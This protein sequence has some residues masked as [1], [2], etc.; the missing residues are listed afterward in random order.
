MPASAPNGA[1][2]KSFGEPPSAARAGNDGDQRPPSAGKAKISKSMKK[3]KFRGKGEGF[4]IA[5]ESD[6]RMLSA[7]TIISSRPELLGIFDYFPLYENSWS[8]KNSQAGELFDLRIILRA[9][10][11]ENINLA[12]EPLVSEESYSSA[13]N[14]YSSAYATTLSEFAMLKI[15]YLMRNIAERSTSYSHFQKLYS[16]PAEIETSKVGNTAKDFFKTQFKFKVN[17]PENYWEYGQVPLYQLLYDLC[18]LSALAS[19]ELLNFHPRK[20]SLIDDKVAINTNFGA[21]MKLV[22]ATAPD[23]GLK[24]GMNLGG[25]N[26]TSS[27]DSQDSGGIGSAGSVPQ[28]VETLCTIIARDLSASIAL[29]RVRDEDSAADQELVKIVEK[30]LPEGFLSKG[31]KQSKMN[32]FKAIA[33]FDRWPRT[34]SDISKFKKERQGK[35][36]YIDQVPRD[37][38][39]TLS[40]RSSNVLYADNISKSY[41]KKAGGEKTFK[42]MKNVVDSAFNLKTG[43]LD[44]TEYKQITE[45]IT[46]DSRALGI[47]YKSLFRLL[48]RKN[49]EEEETYTGLTV[50]EGESPTSPASIFAISLDVLN[51]RYAEKLKSALHKQNKK[52]AQ[53][54]DY[55]RC[56][57]WVF[58]QQF[59]VEAKSILKAFFKDYQTG[60]LTAKAVPSEDEETGKLLDPEYFEPL[61][62]NSASLA[63][64][65]T[66]LGGIIGQIREGPVRKMKT[67]VQQQDLTSLPID[68]D[69][70]PNVVDFTSAVCYDPYISISDKGDYRMNSTWYRNEKVTTSKYKTSTEEFE[71]SGIKENKRYYYVKIVVGEIIDSFLE[72]IRK[73]VNTVEEV[74]PVDGDPYFPAIINIKSPYGTASI[75]FADTYFAEFDTEYWVPTAEKFLTLFTR[76]SDQSLLYSGRSLDD[77]LDH[78]VD[79]MHDILDNNFDFLEL[80]KRE[81][82]RSTT[83]T[84]PPEVDGDESSIYREK[85]YITLNTVLISLKS[86]SE[87]FDSA[88]SNLPANDRTAGS[89][90]GNPPPPPGSG[91]PDPPMWPPDPPGPPPYP[92]APS[93]PDPGGAFDLSYMKMDAIQ[94]YVDKADNLIRKFLS[95]E[96][97]RAGNFSYIRDDVTEAANTQLSKFAAY[98]SETMATLLEEDQTA[99]VGFDIIEK[100]GD[101]VEGYSQ[102]AI[103]ALDAKDGEGDL[104]DYIMTLSKAGNT[105]ADILENINPQQLSL[106]MVTFQRQIGNENE[107]FV[108]YYSLMNNNVIKGIKQLNLNRSLLGTEGLNVRTILV[109]LPA[110]LI[111]SYNLQ[112]GLSL[113]VNNVDLEYNDLVFKPKYYNYDPSVYLLSTDIEKTNFEGVN[114]FKEFVKKVSFTKIK[115]AIDDGTTADPT[116]SI[117]ETDTNI[118]AND[119]DI[120]IFANHTISFL[121]ECYYR[122][123][124]G[125]E[126]NEDTFLSD[127]GALGLGVSTSSINLAGVLSSVYSTVDQSGNAVGINANEL[128]DDYAMAVEDRIITPGDFSEVSEELMSQCRNALTS[129]LLSPEQ[130]RDNILA[131]KMF[132]R[133]F[134]L[135]IDPDEFEIATRENCKNEN[136]NV[137]YTSFKVVNRYLKKRIIRKAGTDEDGNPIYKL[138]SRRKSEGRMAFNQ[139]FVSVGTLVTDPDDQVKL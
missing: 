39:L 70:P 20:L 23:F 37:Y 95:Y 82:A 14:G 8:G 98:C 17:N 66:A 86:T 91:M 90:P 116:M 46:A 117:D 79:C 87:F 52:E 51:R 36:V 41:P 25:S 49:L 136:D 112:N 81:M 60:W 137:S 123:M 50:V 80:K 42:S 33:G 122:I 10:D 69:E 138:A 38:G 133:V 96:K 47:A 21:A 2:K 44:F 58:I 129:R 76:S 97:S 7:K 114:T 134:M 125:L 18:F 3:N 89:N 124:T 40:L 118:S 115:F 64:R 104:K 131:A 53:Q 72:V 109:G 105:G 120:N 48:D 135:M 107:S 34:R 73:V 77:F 57:G 59:P 100:F 32:I 1:G 45:N 16:M 9:A 121:L 92:P 62:G 84:H 127:Y 30:Y 54:I 5:T 24:G 126:V 13:L 101:R 132:D 83:T 71:E 102:T 43:Q 119:S 27:S 85:E 31:T 75:N 11:M 56:Q 15:V 26:T 67:Y 94:H 113:V 28:T 19:P 106:K 55:N 74:E 99:G 6:T 63:S 4:S 110:G 22:Q 65:G 108:P 130:M 78:L 12:F 35:F 29:A 103:A 68:A 61:T 111:D 88:Y 139:F 93:N 128:I